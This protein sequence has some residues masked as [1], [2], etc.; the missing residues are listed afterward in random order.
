[1]IQSPLTLAVERIMLIA[2]RILKRLLTR[3][4]GQGRAQRL[5]LGAVVVVL[6]A[7]PV[8]AFIRGFGVESSDVGANATE[9]V[10]E[11]LDQGSNRINVVLK[12]KSGPRRLVLSVGPAEAYS[13]VND[14]SNLGLRVDQNVTAYTL[15]R[16]IAGALGGRIQRVVVND[17]NDRALFSKVIL[18]TDNR[19]VAVDAATGDA[20]ALALRAKVPIFAERV[21]LDRAGIV[22]SR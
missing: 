8:L 10:V 7:L 11:R 20:V 12:E 22:P 9:M 19:E 6:L 21:V 18:L 3:F 17:A 2:F 15:S 13:I 5:K 1:M 4:A 16:E 14:A